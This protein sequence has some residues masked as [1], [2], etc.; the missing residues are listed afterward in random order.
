MRVSRSFLLTISIAGNF[1]ARIMSSM[2]P[3]KIILSRLVLLSV[4]EHLFLHKF[5]HG[6]HGASV[7]P[8]L[9]RNDAPCLPPLRLDR[10]SAVFVVPPIY[11]YVNAWHALSR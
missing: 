3:D 2:Q 6:H 1:E 9:S 7:I 4:N 8:E 5:I 10:A 11:L